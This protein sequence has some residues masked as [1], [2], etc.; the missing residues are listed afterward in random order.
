M[1]NVIVVYAT[2]Y[3][4]TAEIARAI[5]NELTARGIDTDIFP[6][7]EAPSPEGY[8][9]AVIGSPVRFGAWLIPAVAYLQRYETEIQQMPVAVFTAHV[10]ATDESPQSARQR[11]EYLKPV[12][13]HV[14]PQ[15][16]AFFAGNL[17]PA[18]ISFLENLVCRMIKSPTGDRRDWQ[19]ISDWGKEIFPILPSGT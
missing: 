5:A 7:E 19:I 18:K 12:L 16:T 14:Q 8:Q 4:S 15:H 9:A 6:V 17:D 2:R 3:G 1:S 11:S 13:A 10:L